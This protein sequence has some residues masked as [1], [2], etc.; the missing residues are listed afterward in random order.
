MVLK[1]KTNTHSV[2]I[3]AKK[4]TGPKKQPTKVDLLQ[5][6]KD[7]KRLNNTLELDNTK[8]L[9]V[10]K[11]LQ[12]KVLLL[13]T[14]TKTSL[15]ETGVKELQNKGTQT[16]LDRP[17]FCYECDF[18]A[19]DYHDLGEHMMEFHAFTCKTCD[20]YFESKEDLDE[21]ESKHAVNIDMSRLSC[22]FCENTF[23]TIRD[24][25]SHKKLEHSDKVSIC[26][27]FTNGACHFGDENCWFNHSKTEGTT[28]YKCR[29]CD[30]EF[31]SHADC[32]KHR[33]QEHSLLVPSCRNEAKGACKF[34]S[35][36]CW[37]RHK[38]I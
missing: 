5:E 14:K 24:L 19:E 10:I 32:L 20:D 8:N 2:C 36:T 37:F 1:R 11:I 4:T 29:S 18:P 35:I 27:D 22:N 7:M 30:N 38:D 34:G 26:R 12:E 33:K 21:H 3:D 28:T 15:S 25:M 9:E 31:V 16:E 17:I 6:L 23:G 13:E